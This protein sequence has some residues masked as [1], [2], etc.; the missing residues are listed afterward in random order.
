MKN[1]RR[2]AVSPWVIFVAALTTRLA[3]ALFIFRNYFGPEV[4]FMQNE[5]SHIASALVSHSCFCSPYANTPIAPTAQQ[6]P[7]YPMILAGIFKIFGTFTAASAYAAVGLNIFA[8]AL[9]AVL[10]QRIG[11]HY[12]NETVGTAAAWVW[13]LPWMYRAL[14]FSVSLSSAHLAAL[15]LAAVVLWLP[16]VI[17]T[18]RGWFAV[19]L[20]FG[21]LVLLQA[22]LL[23]VF[24]AYG[25]WLA[26]WKN[27]TAQSMVALCGLLIVLAPW[28]IRNYLVLG[29]LIPVRDNFGLELWLGNRPGMHGTVDY[30]G[31]FPD[32]DPS[33]YARLGE[34]AYMDAK[35]KEA[36]L[37][38]AKNPKAFVD[39]CIHRL[40]E[41]WYVPYSQS[42]LVVPVLAWI[43][44]FLALHRHYR[45]AILAIPL[46]IFPGV[47]YITHI[48][49][50]YRLPIEP[51]VIL[52]ATFSV[53]GMTTPS[54]AHNASR[55]SSFV[56]RRSILI[57]TYPFCQNVSFEIAVDGGSVL[58]RIRARNLASHPLLPGR[59]RRDSSAASLFASQIHTANREKRVRRLHRWDSGNWTAHAAS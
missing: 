36:K 43:G 45:A 8:G 7:L 42:W 58:S 10:L 50:I 9:T 56:F 4:L 13:T 26:W 11:K 46:A 30:S 5:P 2:I 41:F 53:A 23:S 52:L 47:Y 35:S 54:E 15:G 59:P 51:L 22:S 21:V 40:I 32:H 33:T 14:A 31:D 3:S 48:F 1:L 6:S 24:V 34:I 16:K 18:N 29:R 17:V 28:T 57:L 39:R 19:G 25:I 49:P 38:I 37:F 55:S 44:A 12:F 27:R 20:F